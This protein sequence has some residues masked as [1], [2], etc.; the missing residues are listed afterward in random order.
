MAQSLSSILVHLVF[1]TKYRESL[2]KSE[3]ESE[4][5]SYLHGIFRGCKCPSLIIGGTSDHIHSLFSLNRTWA[6]SDLVEEVKKSSSKWMK[7]QGKE[8]RS[9]QWQAGYG[10]FSIG[11]SGIAQ[12]KRYI[13][14][15]KTHH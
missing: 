1:S 4:L 6:V 13:T 11:Q 14:N 2:I 7:A 10:A 9:F 5:Y 3:I 8:F 15:Q 12:V